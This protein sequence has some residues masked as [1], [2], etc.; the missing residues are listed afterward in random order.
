LSFPSPC[1]VLCCLLLLESEET[2]RP[3]RGEER[4]EGKA[5]EERRRRRRRRRESRTRG[6]WERLPLS[7][8]QAQLVVASPSPPWRSALASTARLTVS[9]WSQSVRKQRQ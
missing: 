7:R 5:G 4:R 2:E 9:C 3:Q 1:V 8:P 6:E